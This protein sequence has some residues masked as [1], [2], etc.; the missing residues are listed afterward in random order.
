MKMQIEIKTKGKERIPKELVES[1]MNIMDNYGYKN[2]SLKEFRICDSCEVK[3]PENYP[4]ENE[5]CPNCESG[6]QD[7]E[8]GSI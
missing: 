1:I 3:L 7:A 5:L 4:K 2:G 6:K 8:L